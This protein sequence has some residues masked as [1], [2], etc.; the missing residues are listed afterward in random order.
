MLGLSQTTGQAVRALA[1]LDEPD[2][3]WTMARDIAADSGVS[4]PNVHKLLH[5]LTRAGL[6]DAKRG[7]RG[8]FRL[9]RAAAQTSLYDFVSLMEGDHWLPQCVLG[10]DEDRTPCCCPTQTFWVGI[11]RQIEQEFRQVT[12]AEV[13]ACHRRAKPDDPCQG[14]GDGI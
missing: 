14:R 6:V 9:G 1:C 11:R 10:A 2:G 4:Q 5:Q 8:G 12:L 13:T 7:F 3:R